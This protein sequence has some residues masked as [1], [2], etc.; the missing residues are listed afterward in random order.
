MLGTNVWMLKHAYN[1]AQ[2]SALHYQDLT[3]DCL[4]IT[5]GGTGAI[6]MRKV[7]ASFLICNRR[8]LYSFPDF[9]RADDCVSSTKPL[10]YNNL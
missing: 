1:E 8:S 9:R 4:K 2:F 3:R 7:K 10:D 6:V 5:F